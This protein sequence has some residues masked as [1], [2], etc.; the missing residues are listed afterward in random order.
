MMLTRLTEITTQLHTNYASK[1]HVTAEPAYA[2][3]RQTALNAA[4]DRPLGSWKVTVHMPMLDA[5]APITHRARA[6]TGMFLL[7]L[8]A[9]AGADLVCGV[10]VFAVLAASLCCQNEAQTTRFMAGKYTS[11]ALGGFVVAGSL[12][13]V[14]GLSA[15]VL[16]ARYIR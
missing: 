16:G 5:I 15:L 14:V 9:Q 4:A 13:S 2:N 12:A 10:C 11:A 6:S 1:F 8:A 3:P 7:G